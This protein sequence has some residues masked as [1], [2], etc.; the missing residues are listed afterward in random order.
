MR[1]NQNAKPNRDNGLEEI[2][3]KEG[4]VSMGGLGGGGAQ[5]LR[6]RGPKY[7]REGYTDTVNPIWK[8]AKRDDL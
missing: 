7:P 8:N 2:D 4:M 5:P 3:M 1:L 6:K